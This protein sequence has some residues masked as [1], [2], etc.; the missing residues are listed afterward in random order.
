MPLS[1]RRIAKAVVGIIVWV[2]LVV[3]T[4]LTSFVPSPYGLILATAAS[5]LSVRYSDAVL[6]IIFG[7]EGPSLTMEPLDL[8]PDNTPYEKMH[9]SQWISMAW[10]RQGFPQN[11][12]KC[13]FGVICVHCHGGNTSRCRA[14]VRFF[15]SINIHD[16]K[17]GQNT[18]VE[19]WD[20]GGN[21]NWFSA[22]LRHNLP[23]IDQFNIH[24]LSKYIMNT[25]EDFYEGD[26]KELLLCYVPDNANF[27]AI[28]TDMVG[29][30]VANFA[31]GHPLNFKAEITFTADRL[32]KTT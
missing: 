19:R 13:D 17:S 21:L 20:L 29:L 28:C 26:R 31:V 8:S 23:T 14:S 9:T 12:L 3:L 24:Q 4:S 7:K 5:L 30:P 22:S 27:V 25:S 16:A 11:T 6:D 32:R 2:V 10:V 15:H 1:R 18:T